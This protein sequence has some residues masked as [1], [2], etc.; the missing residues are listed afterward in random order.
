MAIVDA[1]VLVQKVIAQDERNKKNMK[2][3][4]GKELADTFLDR[5]DP[6]TQAFDE[7]R[8]V[9]DLYSKLSLNSPTRYKWGK[10]DTNVRFM[11]DD[12]TCIGSSLSK[13]IS[14]VQTKHHLTV[15]LASRCTEGEIRYL[16]TAD[17]E[18]ST[19]VLML[20]RIVN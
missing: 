3:K 2:I 16:H 7:I 19:A 5:I 9:F 6:I 15:Y 8:V 18:M 20:K 4:A 11:I 1:I 14:N 10:Y 17:H 13:L 12:N